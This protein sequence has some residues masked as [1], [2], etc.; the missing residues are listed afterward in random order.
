MASNVGTG[1]R[2]V[3]AKSYFTESLFAEWTHGRIS[4]HRGLNLILPLTN[5][6]QLSIFV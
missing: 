6:T 5:I 1:Y 2:L 3:F 4:K